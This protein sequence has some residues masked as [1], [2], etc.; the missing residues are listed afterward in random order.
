[1]LKNMLISIYSLTSSVSFGNF[2]II[3][4][5]EAEDEREQVSKM[6]VILE[7]LS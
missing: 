4:L 1:M 5:Q 2:R 6:N 7:K 3:V